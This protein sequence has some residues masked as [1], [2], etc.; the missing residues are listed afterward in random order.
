MPVFRVSAVFLLFLFSLPALAVWGDY[1]DEHIHR[2]VAPSAISFEAPDWKGRQLTFCSGS[3]LSSTKILTAAHC[4]DELRE[5]SVAVFKGHEYEL[6]SVYLHKDFRLEAV[7]DDYWTDVLLEFNAY[8]DLA[9]VE[10][11]APL[12]GSFETVSLL[13]TVNEALSFEKAYFAGFGYKGALFG[14]GEVS[15]LGVLRV[16]QPIEF[17]KFKVL[18]DRISLEVIPQ[19]ACQVDSGGPLMLAGAKPRVIGVVSLG[20]CMT[21][22]WFQPV[23]ENI[24]KLE[25]FK[26]IDF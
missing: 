20:D 6:K 11:K 16:S 25:N 9:I 4:F 18:E 1:A 14:V 21:Y 24:L 15:D 22:S 13:P 3:I 19:G 12:S 23:S 26:R 7:Y 10:L 17:S 2:Q 8:N 5:S